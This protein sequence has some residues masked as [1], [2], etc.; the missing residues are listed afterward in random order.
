MRY[1]LPSLLRKLSSAGIGCSCAMSGR[2]MK[3]SIAVITAKSKQDTAAPKSESARWRMYTSESLK[4]NTRSRR[5]VSCSCAQ[6]DLYRQVGQHPATA[7][8]RRLDVKRPTLSC[9]LRRVVRSQSAVCRL[10]VNLDTFGLLIMQSDSRK[11]VSGQCSVTEQN[12][13]L[14]LDRK[15]T[16]LNSS[17]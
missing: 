2:G 14:G 7:L 12:Q 10:P 15:S 13:F 9:D 3:A 16:R 11:H 6:F 17:H 5:F 8:A 1:G 4:S